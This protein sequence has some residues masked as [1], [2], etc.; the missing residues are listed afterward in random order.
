MTH[1]E[2]YQELLNPK[3][4]LV[5]P[6]KYDNESK[7][8]FDYWSDLVEKYKKKIYS[9]SDES[10]NILD[11]AFEK[12]LKGYEQYKPTKRHN[13]KADF[14]E[15]CITIEEALKLCYMNYYEDAYKLLSEFFNRHDLFYLKM[16]PRLNVEK[17]VFYRIRHGFKPSKG[18]KQDGDLFHLPFHLRHKVAST[19]YGFLGYP[20]FY[21]AGSLQTAWYEMNS[22]DIKSFFYAKFKPKKPLS[23]LDLG[24]PIYEKLEDWEYYS[25]LVFYP[26]IMGCL[27]SV[28]HSDDPFKPEYMLP[29]L[30]TKIIREMPQEGSPENG[31]PSTNKG[32]AGI[33]YMS[34]KSPHKDNLQNLSLRNFALFPRNTICREGYDNIYLSPMFKM[35]DINTFSYSSE[36]LSEEESLEFIK[37]IDNDSSK[38]E[39][40]SI[41]VTLKQ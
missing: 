37:E 1:Q 40:H 13:F 25:F 11:K 18:K 32:F 35:T 16:L 3:S 26:L 5:Y 9:L 21:L 38:D 33:T 19:R 28:K 27:I 41:N 7:D 34:T 36:S 30:M 8:Y 10:V 2:L 31:K 17:Y 15:I 20:V 6:F 24:Y 22:P 29:Q 4:D 12:E 39:F 14:D 23:F